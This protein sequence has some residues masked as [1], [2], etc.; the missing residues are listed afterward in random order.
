MNFIFQS[1]PAHPWLKKWTFEPRGCGTTFREKSADHFFQT[2]E[3]VGCIAPNT[4]DPEWTLQIPIPQNSR[5]NIL[6]NGFCA[7]LERSKKR[8]AAEAIVPEPGVL[9]GRFSGI[10]EPSFITTQPLEEQSDGFQWL[11]ND[12]LPALL[13]VRDDHF[14]LITKARTRTHAIQLAENYFSQNFEELLQKERDNRAGA[15]PLFEE[16]EHHDSLA[17]ISVECMMQALR[18]AEGN[19]PLI[20]SQSKKSEAPEF[21]INELYPL[22][23]AW[24]LIDIKVAEELVLCALRIQ[25][26]SGAIP[27]HYSPHTTHSILEAPKP[28]LIK[29]A[30]AVWEVRKDAELLTAILPPLR[31]HLQWMLHHFD[32]KRRGIY[33]WKNRNEPIVSE[34][35]ETDLATV[36]LSVLLLTEI[37]AFSQLWHQSESQTNPISAF[38]E[39]Q[40]GLES[41]LLDLFWNEEE[42]AFSNAFIRD[43][44]VTFHGFASFTPLLWNKLSDT[45]KGAIIER[46]QESGKLPGGLSVL[47]WRK[48][49]FDDNSSAMLQQFIAFEALKIAEPKGLLMNDYSRLI[50]QGFVEWHTVSIEQSG[51]LQT[52]PVVAA[53]IINVQETRHYRYHAKGGISGALSKLFRKT[54]TDRFDLAVIIIVAFALASSHIIF[55]ILH[56]PPPLGLLEAQLNSAYDSRDLNAALENGYLIIKHYPEEASLARLLAGNVALIHNDL[57]NASELLAGVRATHPDS[58]GPMISL[59]LAY[60]QQGRFQEAEKNY[61][62]FCYLF[63]E[64]FPELVEQVNHFRYLM[65]EGFRV[66]PKWQNI[67][68]YQLMHEL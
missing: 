52:D 24:R 18:P 39:E 9:W 34:S 47:S 64:I 30:L 21:N 28:L 14:C 55:K 58:P 50:L 45:R 56:A 7:Y 23:L 38:K 65:Q 48:S 57:T 22:V 59:G 42:S 12:T 31:R 41:N 16:M 2:Q 5:T 60:Q 13:A 25:A 62:E 4:D 37:E 68:R 20:W 63:D 46:V 11:E 61:D 19:I 15:T 27:V 44:E 29:A 17:A 1:Y 35:Y 32:P 26:G 54:K 8:Y 51:T 3:T 40:D 43:K 36:D 67:Y 49:A 66:P 53:Y 10:P 33:C 6:F